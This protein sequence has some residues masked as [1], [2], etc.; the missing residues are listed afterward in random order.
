[1]L[2]PRILKL[3]QFIGFDGNRKKALKYI[4]AV[5]MGNSIWA[6]FGAITLLGVH[7]QLEIIAGLGNFRDDPLA[8]NHLFRRY[9]PSLIP[10]VYFLLL[11]TFS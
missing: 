3:L 1:M 8:P 2:P 9:L 11:P 5:A 4:E 6:D 10:N 7:L